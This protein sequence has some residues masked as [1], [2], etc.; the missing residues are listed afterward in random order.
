MKITALMENT[1]DSEKIITE[2]G[3]SL[4]VETDKHKVLFDTGRSDAFLSNAQ[5]LGIDLKQVDIAVVSHG[6]FDHTG[7]LK[8]F[9]ELN[10][11]AAVY[12]QC[13]VFIPHYNRVGK[14]I[15]VDQDLRD[16]ARIQFVKDRLDIDDGLK[17]E[18]YHGQRIYLKV[19]NY[20]MTEEIDGTRTADQFLH[21]QYLIITEGDKKVLLSGC[22]HRG[23]CNIVQWAASEYVQT[24][25]GGFH[26]MQLE[27]E[28][29][30]EM[31][32]TAEKLLEY[33]ITYYTCHCTGLEQYKYIK[34]K[35]GERV[36]Y[37][38]S[39]QCMEI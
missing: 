36:Q 16:N 21:E 18:T 27:P 39:G 23:I 7:G 33:P 14:Y 2:H 31:A 1:G 24:V 38:K 35:M 30:S 4:Y 32:E 11:D 37:M 9:L 19:Q 22:S 3:L 10:R 20:G 8:A 17:I 15:G 25:I 26:F 34:E 13:G 29:F 12:M 6:H 28:R 5:T